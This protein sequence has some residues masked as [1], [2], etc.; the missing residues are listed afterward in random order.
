MI[1]KINLILN[2]P[3]S[4]CPQE[5]NMST[6]KSS[7]GSCLARCC[8]CCIACCWAATAAFWWWWWWCR[9]IWW[10]LLLEVSISTSLECLDSMQLSG[11]EDS[12][13]LLVLSEI[14]ET[15]VSLESVLLFESWLLTVE[16]AAIV[17]VWSI[18]IYSRSLRIAEHLWL[19]HLCT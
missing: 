5:V 7:L 16:S 11:L 12:F 1:K 14:F 9:C 18:S 3:K 10:L 2:S 19:K 13:E 15:L 8:C 6:L 17:D 4:S